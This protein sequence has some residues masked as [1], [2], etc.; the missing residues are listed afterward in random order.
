MISIL[1]FSLYRFYLTDFLII[2]AKRA[3]VKVIILPHENLKDFN[4]LQDFIKEGIQ[5]HFVKNYE[6]VFKIVFP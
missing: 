5:V 3:G 1:N 4:E 2:K 6:D